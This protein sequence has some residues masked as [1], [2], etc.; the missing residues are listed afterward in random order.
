MLV[1]RHILDIYDNYRTGMFAEYVGTTV[2]HVLMGS[3]VCEES[4]EQ[5]LVMPVF[6][7]LCI[8]CDHSSRIWP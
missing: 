8:T 6:S 3:S 5:D 1:R 4:S 2:P 7:S